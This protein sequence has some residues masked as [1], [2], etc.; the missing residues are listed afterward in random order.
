MQKEPSPSTA[1]PAIQPLRHL[2]TSVG[3]FVIRESDST[4]TT[5]GVNLSAGQI[6]AGRLLRT[7]DPNGNIVTYT[8]SGYSDAQGNS[9]TYTPIQGGLVVKDSVG[10]SITYLFDTSKNLAS[11]T[12]RT[13]TTTFSYMPGNVPATA[14]ALQSIAFPDGV[15]EFF[16]YDNF[17]RLSKTNFDNNSTPVTYSYGATGQVTITNALG[18]QM[19]LSADDSGVLSRVQDPRAQILSGKLDGS[20]NPVQ[21]SD[22]TG[23][24]VT[25]SYDSLGNLTKSVDALGNTIQYTFDPTTDTL[26]SMTDARGIKTTYV[27]DSHG[28]LKTIAYPDGTTEQYQYDAIGNVT[29]STNRL[30][31]STFYTY[32]SGSLVTRVQYSDGSI[33]IYTY[34]A[35]RNLATA[36]DNTGVT[37]FTYDAADHLTRIVYPDGKFI[38]Y[39]YNSFGLRTQMQCKTVTP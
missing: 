5:Y 10:R 38:A 8:A 18:N 3:T 35:H 13:G 37:S 34:D 25:A 17:G 33:V 15:H 22:E 21:I 24:K 32:G 12:D 11:V 26:T 19:V 16:Q 36:T 1:H 2:N 30:G 20:G 28:N 7:Q 6:Q 39:T 31:K 27:R 14:H 4:Q 23:G 9:V 29:Q